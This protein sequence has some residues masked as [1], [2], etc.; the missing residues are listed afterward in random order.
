MANLTASWIT[1]RV[2]KPKKSILRSP[3]RSMVVAVNCV[4]TESSPP[5]A[6]GTYSSM[7]SLPITTPAACI[8]VFLGS[9]S[10]LSAIS[11]RC[12]TSGFC[13]Y[14][15]LRS[16]LT[17]RALVMVILSSIGTDLATASQRAYGRSRT[18][19]TSLITFLAAI[20]WKVTIC[21]TFSLP[22]F[23]TT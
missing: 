6:R 5:L 21:T 11:I 8:P 10:S 9:P 7:E 18:L 20:V 4:I 3:R 15:S 16:L 14:I 23:L 2:L 12:L 17:E 19:P 1:V 22:Y 13:S